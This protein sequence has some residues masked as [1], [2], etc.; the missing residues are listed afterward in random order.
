MGTGTGI[1]GIGR[2]GRTLTLLNCMLVSA[3]SGRAEQPDAA[4]SGTTTNAGLEEMVVTARRMKR[5][6]TDSFASVTVID[7]EDILRSNAGSVPGVL[8]D[9]EGVYVEDSSG[10]GTSSKVNLRGFTTA[11]SGHHLV[12]VDGVPQNSVSDKLVDWNLIPLSNIDR[13]EIVRGP[14]STLYGENAMSG[15]I[16]IITKRRAAEPETMFRTSYGSFDTLRWRIHTGRPAGAADYLVSLGQT[17]TDGYRDHA[18]AEYRDIS[19]RMGLELGDASRLSAWVQYSRV[20]RGSHP[21]ALSEQQLI[22]DRNQARPGTENDSGES[23][24]V[25]AGMMYDKEVNDAFSLQVTAHVRNEDGESFYTAGQTEATTAEILHGETLGGLNVAC[26]FEPQLFGKQNTVVAGLDLEQGTY[27]YDKFSAPSRRRG[28][29]LADYEAVRDRIGVYVE[30]EVAVGDSL[31][32]LMGGRHSRLEYD[33]DDD[34]SAASNRDRTLSDESFR[35]GA[36]Y[37]YRGADPAGAAQGEGVLFGHVS[38]AFRSPTLGQMF[39][40]QSA[41][42]DLAPET[43]VNYEVGLRD[44]IGEAVDF[45][46]GLYWME[47]E[48]E[49]AYDYASSMYANYGETSHRGVEVGAETRSKEGFR[50]FVNYTYT[51][52]R[53]ESGRNEG[54]DL[55]HVPRHM[56]NV[57]IGYER[58]SSWGSTLSARLVGSSYLD[59]ANS[60][61]LS[62][63]QTVNIEGWY[64]IGRFRIFAEI[65][66][67]LDEE[68]ATYGFVSSGAN[69]YSPAPGTTFTAGISGT[70]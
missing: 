53:N 3:A 55:A 36:D 4:Q 24:K 64:A 28:G 70:F 38:Q 27:D 63:Y 50:C 13:I 10:V 65:G 17:T 25:S 11:M 60:S 26:T 44:G 18:D 32:V 59:S 39:T 7:S 49:I 14:L 35:I 56:G 6:I 9:C 61:T 12:L 29:S 2:V 42:P 19:G 62:G 40:Y 46:L 48:D 67:L 52:A 23:D 20:E 41:N 5:P 15:V 45:R 16:N 33:F 66:N 43:A 69:Y 30:D 51:E 54:K 37:A 47:V 58:G 21:W 8:S 57:G 31:R 1:E 68:Y 22:G 34:L